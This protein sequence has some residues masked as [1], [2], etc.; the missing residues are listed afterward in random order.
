L[1]FLRGEVR[2]GAPD[3]EQIS[4]SSYTRAGPE[5]ANDGVGSIGE[6]GMRGFAIVDG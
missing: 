5:E 2:F 3:F 6:D 4:G 1:T